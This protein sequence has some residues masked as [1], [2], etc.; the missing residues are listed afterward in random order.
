MALTKRR[1]QTLFWICA[2]FLVVFAAYSMAFAARAVLTSLDYLHS[3]GWITIF[4]FFAIAMLRL[5][6][7]YRRIWSRTSGHE[8]IVIVK[9]I[10]VI[11]IGTF[12]T[13]LILVPRPLPLSIVL[14]GNLLSLAGFTA[15]RYQSR[16][17]NGLV[18]RWKAIWDYQFPISRTR[19]LIIGAGESGQTLAWRLKYRAPGNSYE[20]VGFIDDDLEKQKMLIEGSPVIGT[21]SDIIRIAK[22]FHIDLIVVAIT[23]IKGQAFRDL[24]AICEN[25]S[26]LIKVVPDLFAMVSAREHTVPL[27]DVRAEDLIGRSALSRCDDVSLDPVMHKIVCITGASGSIGSEL[28]RQIM[29]YQPQMVILIDNNESGLH[30]LF[31]QVTT[32]FP[33]ID[34]KIVLADITNSRSIETVIEMYRPQVIFHAAAYKHVPMLEYYPREG[35]RVN[36][37]GTWCVAQLAQK[38]DVERFILVS[39]DKAVNPVSVM[40]A[41]KRVCEILL[42]AL[43]KHDD[44]TTLFASVRFGNVL[45]SRGSV[46]PTF[47]QQ[48]DSGGPVTVTHPDMTRYFMSISE[49]VNLIIHAACM[50]TGDDIFMLKMGEVVRIT[51][52]AERMIRMHGLRPYQ[53]I[54]IKF[55]GVRPGEK[56]HEE[57]F[58]DE[59]LSLP[60]IHPYII[61]IQSKMKPF[62]VGMF[63]NKLLQLVA[64]E[65]LSSSEVL[66]VLQEFIQSAQWQPVAESEAVREKPYDVI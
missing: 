61:R 12:I 33:D 24:L 55:T 19:V 41:S 32:T 63:M 31:I 26:A 51:E 34:V 44:N 1:Q 3:I 50:T 30:D 64:Q 52:L 2:D 11:T 5:F 39:T 20:V 49:A 43:S 10:T 38:Y 18:W 23:S 4:A 36:I 27:R 21:Q 45:G 14:L 58:N 42:H 17:L 56:M 13:S 47:N 65:P 6:G 25:T 62:N 66:S 57:L 15:S 7:V 16:L 28:T 53:D 37:C 29:L 60:T 9:A 54:A 40:G 35:L 46:V 22:D 59:E 8:V 48:I